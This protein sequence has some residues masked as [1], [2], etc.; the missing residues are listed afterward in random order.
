M[1]MNLTVTEFVDQTASASPVPG[2]GSV[3]A[4]AGALAAA[5]SAM[6]AGLTLGRKGYDGVGKD[7]EA[8]FSKAETLRRELMQAVD[9]DCKAY[10]SF[11]S[12]LKLPKT[13]SVEE[14]TRRMEIQAAVKQICEVPL[15]IA[16]SALAML[17]LASE[18]V[19]KGRNDVVT[20]AAVSVL[21]ARA[22]VRGALYNVRFN[23]KSSTDAPYVQAILQQVI[24]MELAA[25][26]VEREGLEGIAV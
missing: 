15:W 1:L 18:A 25:E 4:L 9:L 8:L 21:L 20:D 23:L 3:S 19:A 7:M 12:A 14:E 22:A 16:K 24:E 17:N 2:G 5:L 11:L 10:D 6:V 13:N 26:R